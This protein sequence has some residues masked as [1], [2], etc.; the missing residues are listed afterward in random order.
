MPIDDLLPELEVIEQ[1]PLAGRAA[2]YA[3]LHEELA[4]QLDAGPEARSG[5]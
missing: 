5:S 4:K 1:Q 2:A 3:R